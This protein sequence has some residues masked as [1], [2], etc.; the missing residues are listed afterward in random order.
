MRTFT[1]SD[2]QEE[3]LEKWQAKHK[4]KYGE[5]GMLE[6]RFTCTGIGAGVIVKNLTHKKKIDLTEYDKW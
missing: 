6:F 4:K 2:E 1:L 5:Y 3:K